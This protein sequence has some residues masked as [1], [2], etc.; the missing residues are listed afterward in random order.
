[1][2]TIMT[3]FNVIDNASFVS[4]DDLESCEVLEDSLLIQRIRRGNNVQ[5]KE[6][7]EEPEEDNVI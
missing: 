4:Q 1:M 3:Q 5:A 2:E 6:K 7:E